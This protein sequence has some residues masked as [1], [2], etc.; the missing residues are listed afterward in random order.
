MRF[1]LAYNLER[2]STATEMQQLVRNSIEIV[3]LAERSGFEL[4]YAAEHHLNELIIAPN[5][6]L[7]LMIWAQH[8]SRIRLASG[9]AVAPYWHPV[10]L[11]G[12]AAFVDICSNGRLELGVGSGAFQ[13]EF[14]RMAAGLDQ[15]SGYRYLQEI[16]PAVIQLWQGDCA[17]DGEFWKFPLSTSVPKPVQKPHPPIWVAARSPITYDWAVPHGY[18]IVC[19]PLARPLSELETYKER[20]DAA[21][22]HL[23]PAKKRPR[24]AAMRH[25]LVYERED[26]W[27]EPVDRVT[28][29][30][31]RFGNL[32]GTSGRVENGFPAQVDLA[33]LKSQDTFSSRATRENLMFGRPDEIIAKLEQY[34]AIGVDTFVYFASFGMAHEAVKRSLKLFAEEVMPAFVEPRAGQKVQNSM[35]GATP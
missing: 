20:F 21:L 34:E 28:E 35:D 3:E 33:T 17:H 14:D 31:G 32:F 13:Y 8:T 15:K 1:Q 10:K 11:A 4:V 9:M 27:E 26:G 5:P 16:V 23:D 12:E 30:S 25:A 22:K 29:W 2:Y 19:W 24:F 7:L 18:N 6:F